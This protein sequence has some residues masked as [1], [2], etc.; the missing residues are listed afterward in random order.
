M[1]ASSSLLQAGFRSAR[2]ALTRGNQCSLLAARNLLPRSL[3]HQ[4]RADFS[5]ESAAGQ[6]TSP[7]H[8]AVIAPSLAANAAGTADAAAAADAADAGVAGGAE[9]GFDARP[10]PLL[11]KLLNAPRHALK[12]EVLRKFHG[13]GL[14]SA[15]VF[16]VL[17]DRLR[18]LHWHLEFKSTDAFKKAQAILGAQ[19][20]LGSRILRLEEYSSRDHQVAFHNKHH[21]PDLWG[22]RD[23]SLIMMGLPDDVKTEEIEQFF[24]DYMLQPPSVYHVRLQHMGVKTPVRLR[25]KGEMRPIIDLVERRAVVRFADQREALRALREKHREFLGDRMVELRLLQ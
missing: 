25:M 3:Q 15:D 9:K 16:T 14:T 2:D 5:T 7:E 23:V 19:N 6:E 18:T 21:N 11:V 12:E 1:A 4:E 10:R 22:W 24:E 20:R 17:D 8:P 13:C